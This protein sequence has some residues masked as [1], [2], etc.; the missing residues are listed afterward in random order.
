M[1]HR[2]LLP[3]GIVLRDLPLNEV[4]DVLHVHGQQRIPR[5]RLAS[6]REHR[7]VRLRLA[8]DPR[9]G[10][11]LGAGAA[12]QSAIVKVAP[13]AQGS[14]R[15]QSS[16]IPYADAICAF[17]CS[18]PYGSRLPSGRSLSPTTLSAAASHP[19]P[20]AS[21]GRAP[22]IQCAPNAS[23]AR[24]D[25]EGWQLH[26]NETRLPRRVVRRLEHDLPET[27]DDGSLDRGSASPG[28]TER[29]AVVDRLVG[30][31]VDHEPSA[32]R[33]D[34]GGDRAAHARDEER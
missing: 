24:E 25:R 22:L 17:A 32:E 23:S 31:I 18:T 26:V 30:E 11:A 3:L 34:A 28:E 9:E 5:P 13:A 33:F 7:H 2:R 29:E 19:E 21:R 1:V 8:E 16:A 4:E 10:R 15:N 14:A 6:P 20:A 12:A 27:G